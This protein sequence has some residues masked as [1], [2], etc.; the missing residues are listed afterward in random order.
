[1]LPTWGPLPCV[2]TTC[3]PSA[4]R[5]AMRRARSST[6]TSCSSNVPTWPGCR[7]ALPPRAMT[8][9]F[10]SVLNLA[11]LPVVDTLAGVRPA[12]APADQTRHVRRL[13]TD[14]PAGV[15]GPPADRL[16]GAGSVVF[17]C[18]ADPRHPASAAAPGRSRRSR[19]SAGS[20]SMPMSASMSA[21]WK[22]MRFSGLWEDDR[23]RGVDDLVGD[24]FAA[25][26]RQAVHE[27]GAGLRVAPELGVDLERA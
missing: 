26:G 24:L 11:P 21:F 6:L 17:R 2:T 13:V 1:M 25:H 19:G 20:S 16:F 15:P 22:C 12:E 23:R 4:T 8:T 18:P 5:R 7:M 27:L 3:Q 14:R 9:V 10:F